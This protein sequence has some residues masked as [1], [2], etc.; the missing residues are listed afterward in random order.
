MLI[1]GY[2]PA[3]HCDIRIIVD[4][5]KHTFSF[6]SKQSTT[7]LKFPEC[8][9]ACDLGMV[10]AIQDNTRVDKPYVF[11]EDSAP[12]QKYDTNAHYD[13]ELVGFAVDVPHDYTGITSR[14]FQQA[15]L[16]H[17]DHKAYKQK[18]K[19]ENQNFSDESYSDSDQ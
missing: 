11:R 10:L 14:S 2:Y 17:H 8:L 5:E 15:S 16:L 1:G 3:H 19:S 9:Q 4:Q 12:I 7:I 13:V 6:V 18:L